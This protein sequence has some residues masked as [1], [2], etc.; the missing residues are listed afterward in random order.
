MKTILTL[1]IVIVA[2]LIT[3][4][5]FSAHQIKQERN[6]LAYINKELSEQ[7]K[8]LHQNLNITT[9]LNINNDLTSIDQ[10]MNSNPEVDS[11]LKCDDQM[12]IVWI[13]EDH[14]MP[15][16]EAIFKEI[17]KVS[18]RNGFKLLVLT[19]FEIARGYKIF[20]KQLPDDYKSINHSLG[21]PDHPAF[22]ISMPVMFIKDKTSL[23][24]FFIADKNLP[25]LTSV[26][27]EKICKKYFDNR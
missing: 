16:V 4:S 27:L 8:V 17:N 3:Y 14:C 2:L 19:K 23:K 5:L 10:L 20:K 22:N 12:L 13:R 24:H 6:E 26:Y 25:Q 21:F 1:L 7:Y 9:M 18:N 15:C 11:L